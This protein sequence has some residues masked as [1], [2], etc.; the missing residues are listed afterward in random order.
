MIGFSQICGLFSK[1]GTYISIAVIALIVVVCL[2]ILFKF[3][4]T[5][6]L[7]LYIIG[8][9]VIL[10]GIVCGVAF[11]KEVTA[12]SYVN[13]SINIENQFSVES[14][15]YG[16]NNVVFY[17][18]NEDTTQTYTYSTDLLKVQDFN[19]EKKKYEVVVNDYVLPA[20][21]SAGAVD[22]VLYIDFYS[23]S[24]DLLCSSE[25]KISIKFFSDKTQLKFS[26]VGQQQAQ[27]LEQYFKDNGI[28]LKINE[29]L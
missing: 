4:H 28:H 18:N 11:F 23:T 3:E 14:F 20:T 2:V 22:T 5:R 19:G 6:K 15:Q 8:S 29:I 16:S 26:V 1:T 10:S 13:G 25:M 9:L 27:F 12:E 24:G 7:M 17:H 21:V